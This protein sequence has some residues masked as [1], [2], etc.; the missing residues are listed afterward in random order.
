METET[1]AKEAETRCGTLREERSRLEEAVDRLRKETKGEDKHLKEQRAAL[2]VCKP[3][4][5]CT[6]RDMA[7]SQSVLSGVLESPYLLPPHPTIALASC[8]FIIL[9]FTFQPP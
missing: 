2:Q 6:C 7:I 3:L 4:S 5:I 8:I 1:R 9:I